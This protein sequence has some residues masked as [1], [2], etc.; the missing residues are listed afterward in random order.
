[1]PA[2]TH[3][4]LRLDDK[5]LRV[6]WRGATKACGVCGR[7]RGLFRR[8]VIM[9]DECPRCGLTFER[10]EG[11]YI[12][13]VGINT[14][15]SFGLLVLLLSAFFISTYPDIPAG[16][17]VFGAAAIYGLVPVFY[18]P[19]SKTLWTAIDLLMRPLE[20]GEVRHPDDWEQEA[21]RI[22]EAPAEPDR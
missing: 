14:I 17:W 18:Y 5:T 3:P 9:A 4:D 15:V 22:G 13:A 20:P 11:H 10:T 7:R 2:N 8:W 21:W 1:V 19:I 16:P 12:G 6:L